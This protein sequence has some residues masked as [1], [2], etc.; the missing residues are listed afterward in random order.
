MIRSGVILITIVALSLPIEAKNMFYGL[1]GKWCA[2][3]SDV[4]QFR[5]DDDGSLIVNENDG[6]FCQID[7]ASNM[8]TPFSD[9]V[10]TWVCKAGTKSFKEKITTY[11][12]PDGKGGRRFFPCA[13][14]PLR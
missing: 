5:I 10:V 9:Y 6:R 13:A 11:E 2:V 4:V 12:K 8:S 3:G 14:T 1:V 7:S